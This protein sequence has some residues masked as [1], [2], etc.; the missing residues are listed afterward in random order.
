MTTPTEACQR[1]RFVTAAVP[2]IGV[3][4]HPPARSRRKVL[5]GWSHLDENRGSPQPRSNDLRKATRTRASDRLAR[6]SLHPSSTPQGHGWARSRPEN[7]LVDTNFW[8][9]R[10][11]STLFFR[12]QQAASNFSPSFFSQRSVR[13]QTSSVPSIPQ[14][15]TSKLALFPSVFAALPDYQTS[16]LLVTLHASPMAGEAPAF[17]PRQRVSPR[18]AVAWTHS[19]PD[20]SSIRQMDFT[21]CWNHIRSC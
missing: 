20:S 1:T 18:D 11:F 3:G 8:I 13:R 15:M 5:K 4:H 2:G 16:I 21:I 19:V 12:W 14:A 9:A 6:A 10:C 17:P 7:G